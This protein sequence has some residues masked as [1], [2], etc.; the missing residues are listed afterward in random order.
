MTGR[1]NRKCRD[2]GQDRAHAIYQ[3]LLDRINA[4]Y[5]AGNFDL[6]QTLI[7]LPHRL[8]TLE[9]TEELTGIED[10]RALF[11]QF[12]SPLQK[13]GGT[14]FTRISAAARFIDDDTIEGTHVTRI[15]K[16]N[17]H[18]RGPYPV[19]SLLA[20]R[21]GR[22]QMIASDYPLASTDALARIL[23]QSADETMSASVPN[24]ENPSDRSASCAAPKGDPEAIA[25]AERLL[26][27][28]GRA[29]E[30]GDF[31][32]LI[33]IVHLPHK[34]STFEATTVIETEE[35]LHQTFQ[36]IRNHLRATGMTDLIRLCLAAEFSGPDRMVW[37]H[38]SHMLARGV[39]LKTPYPAYS[40]AVRDG[41]TWKIAE[42]R[43]ALEDDTP[44][45]R[46]MIAP[47]ALKLR[48]ATRSTATPTDTA[49]GDPRPD[50]RPTQKNG[51]VQ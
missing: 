5:N 43:Y 34:M 35:D 33:D 3:D 29:L 16:G 38:E 22:W 31:S 2:D 51:E 49:P 42:S 47:T 32:R 50:P 39:W 15:K 4:A 44:Q 6:F 40:V 46:A 27:M 41:D 30:S 1:F 7:G 28:T 20:H 12:C 13:S 23:A 19:K 24:A 37:A 14:G 48:A 10:L 11:D 21:D 26:D 17:V 45:A 9:R 18:M 36:S 8:T 25:L